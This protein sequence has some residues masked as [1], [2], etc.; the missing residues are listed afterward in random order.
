MM[1]VPIS[2]SLIVPAYNEAA[3]LPALLDS[4]E[5]ARKEYQLGAA[6][7]EVIVADNAS[8]D[9][10]AAIAHARGCRVVSVERP[11]IAAAR[12]GGAKVAS[13]VI[14]A[15]VDAD[16][17]IHPQTFNAIEDMMRTQVVV[18]ATGVTLSRMSLPLSFMMALA[19]PLAYIAGMDTGVV[20]CRRQDW[21][22]VGGYDENRL[23]AEDVK[24]LLDLKRLGRARGQRFGRTSNAR[25]VT[26]TRK[27][28]RHGDVRFMIKLLAMP[29][30][31]VISRASAKRWIIRHWYEERGPRRNKG[32]AP[33][34]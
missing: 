9:E 23:V 13:G 10:T 15:F 28:D 22:E 24:F 34:P 26:S 27:F 19:T 12:N 14:L 16:S 2:I 1:N 8:S 6:A 7:V 30:L 4:V 31:A 33:D 21:Q 18:G 5:I 3:F 20:F 29:L 11:S 25:T 32:A 17:R